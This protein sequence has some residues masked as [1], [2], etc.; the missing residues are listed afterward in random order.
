MFESHYRHTFFRILVILAIS[1][2]GLHDY[3]TLGLKEV[4]EIDAKTLLYLLSISYRFKPRVLTRANA[5]SQRR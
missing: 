2:C 3:Y 4:C 1:E 5:A